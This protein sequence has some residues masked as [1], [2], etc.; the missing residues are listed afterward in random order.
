M[1]GGLVYA[2]IKLD[3]FHL[4]LWK[5]KFDSGFKNFYF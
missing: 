4:I 1:D 2:K 3:I 5:Q